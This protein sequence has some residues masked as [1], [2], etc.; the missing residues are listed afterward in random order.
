VQRLGRRLHERKL[1]AGLMRRAIIALVAV[2]L[3]WVAAPAPA[4]AAQ[5]P[6]TDVELPILPAAGPT[7]QPAGFTIDAQ[8]AA[9]TAR[10][11]PTMQAIHRAEHPLQ[12]RVY[13]WLRSHYEV[14]FFYKGK[15][16]GD[17][18]VGP[19]GRRLQTYTG[20]L[21]S[22]FYARAAY[23][24]V[25]DSPWVYLPFG[26]A[27]LLPLA[28]LRGRSWMDLLDVAAVLAFGVSYFLFDNQHVEAAVWLAYPPLLYLL[29]RMLVRGLRHRPPRQRLTCRLPIAF[30]AVG[31]LLLVAGRVV[32]TLEPARV[33][34]VGTA[35][36]IGA[37]KILHGQ[38]IYFPSLGHPD[39]YGP[40]AYLAYVPFQA[41]WPGSWTYVP[42]ARAAAITFDLLTIAGLVWFGVRLRAGAEGRRLGLLLAWL[43]AAC[44]FT[45]LGMVKSTND[46]LVALAVVA[47]MLSLTAPVRRGVLVGLGA[48][49]KF[50]PA[51]VLPLMA[52]GLRR[53]GDREVRKVLVGFAIA[54]G[55]SVAL[56]LPPGGLK[57]MYDHTIGYQLTRTDIFS[58]WALHPALA[59]LKV[60]L[61][62]AVVALATVLAFHPGGVRTTAQVSALAAALIIAVQLPAR[63][64]FYLY[65][66]WFLPAVLIAVLGA[67]PAELPELVSG[68]PVAAVPD[69][70]PEL[71]G[72]V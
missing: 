25:F 16:V 46:G 50:F 1:V 8:Q 2:T 30:L 18:L 56:F 57:E 4:H 66:V 20:P 13:V 41:L 62:V 60:V 69:L 3:S 67:Q 9:L 21:M 72:A 11:S 68:E 65:I 55:L 53:G 63:P 33:L 45:V 23:S 52:V 40:I 38:S 7:T 32:V 59:P 54:A 47:V 28:F 39:T 36:A 14:Y 19:H 61:E 43:W 35:S 37:Y 5:A 22:G 26:L 44:P 42:A 71:V 64:W 31:L 34:D 17:V 6:L 29:G 51:I 70:Q 24:N 15:P 48:A 27:F 49:A 12:Y 58:A 10:T